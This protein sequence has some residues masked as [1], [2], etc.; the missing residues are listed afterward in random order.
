MR[1][2]PFQP[3]IN[4][5]TEYPE[6]PPGDW[7]IL[8]EGRDEKYNHYRASLLVGT[9]KEAPTRDWI[10]ILKIKHFLRARG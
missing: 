2:S 4:S 10:K 3:D 5:V 7:E 8:I 1:K 6:D 9:N